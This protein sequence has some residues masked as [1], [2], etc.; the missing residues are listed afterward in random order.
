[1]RDAKLSLK[2]RHLFAD[3]FQVE[4]L[5]LWVGGRCKFEPW[6]LQCELNRLV[7]L[8][9][10]RVHMDEKVLQLDPYWTRKLPIR[11][12]QRKSRLSQGAP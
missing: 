12:S 7:T 10:R 5:G 3:S 8:H 9:S 6:P 2:D 11:R 4:D 1:L